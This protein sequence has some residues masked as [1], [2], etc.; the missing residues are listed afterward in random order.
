[1]IVSSTTVVDIIQFR[2]GLGMFD[3]DLPTYSK[4]LSV[5]IENDIVSLHILHNQGSPTKYRIAIVTN[6]ME[7]P[8][9]GR[10]KGGCTAHDADYVGH[11]NYLGT[12]HH[13]FWLKS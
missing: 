2:I 9:Y 12:I 3:V 4:I 7:I 1:M 11:F 10:G 6:A 13:V 8:F 5:T